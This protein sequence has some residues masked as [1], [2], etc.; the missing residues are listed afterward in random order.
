MLVTLTKRSNT[1]H[2]VEYEKQLLYEENQKSGNVMQQPMD[3][4]VSGINT[5]SEVFS[6]GHIYF[7]RD[8]HIPVKFWYTYFT[9]K[10]NLTKQENFLTSNL[11]HKSSNA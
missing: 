9:R 5:S 1:Q 11:Y 3:F 2:L 10:V 7:S 6:L 8:K 4:Y